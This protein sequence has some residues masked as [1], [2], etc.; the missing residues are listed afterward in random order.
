MLEQARDRLQAQLVLSAVV[1][2]ED[3]LVTAP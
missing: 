3:R 2:R 1:R